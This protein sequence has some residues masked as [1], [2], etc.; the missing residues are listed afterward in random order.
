M[1]LGDLTPHIKCP[2]NVSIVCGEG[3]G[4]KGR[5]SAL[6]SLVTSST[7]KLSRAMARLASPFAL[8]PPPSSLTSSLAFPLPSAGPLVD[9]SSGEGGW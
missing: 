1:V 9:W 7:L 8:P 5:T 4:N 6:S 2:L 3:G